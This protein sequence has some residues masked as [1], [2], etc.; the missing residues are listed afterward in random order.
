MKCS[1]YFVLFQV[2]HTSSKFGH[3]ANWAGY[4]LMGKDIVLRDR[5]ADLARSLRMM[6]Q[7]P[8]DYLVA[9]LKTLQAMVNPPPPLSLSCVPLTLAICNRWCLVIKL[10]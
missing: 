10:M 1:C 5:S 6:L 2:V 7:S 4:M 9:T 8:Q 3:P